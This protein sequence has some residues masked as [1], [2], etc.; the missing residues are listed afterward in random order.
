MKKYLLLA[1]LLVASTLG[2]GVATGKIGS[3][4]TNCCT[5]GVVPPPP[6]GYTGNPELR[7]ST[8]TTSGIAQI[9]TITGG[10]NTNPAETKYISLNFT[11]ALCPGVGTGCVNIDAF[12]SGG[13][14]IDFETPHGINWDYFAVWFTSSGTTPGGITSSATTPL[15]YYGCVLT[16][17][18][19]RIYP[20][21]EHTEAGCTDSGTGYPVNFTSAGTGTIT[22]VSAQLYY[23]YDVALAAVTGSGVN[24]RA[25][26]VYRNGSVV[27]VMITRPGQDFAIG[28]QVTVA[29]IA[30]IDNITGFS[31]LV[32]D[33]GVARSRTTGMT[34][35]FVQVAA[36]GIDVTGGTGL[37]GSGRIWTGEDLSYTWDCG[38]TGTPTI[39]MTRPTDGATVNANTDQTGMMA[40]CRYDVAGPY[41]I[42]VTAS[43]VTSG[44]TTISASKTVSVT[45]TAYSGTERFFCPGDPATAETGLSMATCFTSTDANAA[46]RLSAWMGG[47]TGRV[48]HIKRGTAFTTGSVMVYSGS[49]AVRAGMRVDDC[50]DLA[51][52]ARWGSGNNPSLTTSTFGIYL[53]QSATSGSMTDFVISNLD[54]ITTAGSC[55]TLSPNQNSTVTTSNNMYLN[56]VNCT[57]SQANPQSAVAAQANAGWFGGTIDASASVGLTTDGAYITG[58]AQRWNFLMGLTIIGAG[59]GSG[60]NHGTYQTISPQ[61]RTMAY[62]IGRWNKIDSL[63]GLS[64]GHKFRFDQGGSWIQFDGNSVPNAGVAASYGAAPDPS[65]YG[66]FPMI[67]NIV[68]ENSFTRGQSTSQPVCILGNQAS[69]AG[70]TMRY[71]R[72]VSTASQTVSLVGGSFLTSPY[73]N[74]VENRIYSNKWNITFNSTTAI[75]RWNYFAPNHF[76]GQFPLWTVTPAPSA[77]TI[78]D[79]TLVT[80]SPLTTTVVVFN[81]NIP[82]M[83][84]NGS[85]IVRNNYYTQD[86]TPFS[87]EQAASTNLRS[88]SYWQTTAGFDN[89]G[90]S[91]IDN[92]LG[93]CPPG[94]TCPAASWTD[95]GSNP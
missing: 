27:D 28:D 72:M 69:T 37:P 30:D 75:A 10:L 15:N 55:V 3:F 1:A 19:L 47:G 85:R 86:T 91:V 44:G 62:Y 2:A 25:T 93:A 73:P 90:T 76:P 9:G 39:S 74:M 94:W 4:A 81:I 71:N 33:V 32:A 11:G 88:F 60:R 20:L 40:V 49:S 68:C 34:P 45:A 13:E 54:I 46:N 14:Y 31:F 8:I 67:Q 7:I 92:T 80:S 53:T 38:N 89:D 24:A 65:H 42:T 63:G 17:T 95:F 82:V 22:M 50:E 57:S 52:T 43:G 61:G 64:D 66:P 78:V 59:N 26:V 48:A 79:N 23:K 16:S 29:N 70:G 6:A 77:M 5:T 35:F 36:S 56:N 18:R 41:D 83:Q 12:G 58:G 84:S 87:D 51:C 21:M